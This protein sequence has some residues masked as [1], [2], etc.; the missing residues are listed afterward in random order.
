MHY[1]NPH[2]NVYHK[3]DSSSPGGEFLLFLFMIFGV[4]LMH[5]AA[6]KSYHLK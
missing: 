1:Y 4:F 6:N 5:N 3:H 2:P